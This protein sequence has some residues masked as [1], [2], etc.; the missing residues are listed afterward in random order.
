[1]KHENAKKQRP[2]LSPQHKQFLIEFGKAVR[3]ARDA[4]HWSQEKL[5]FKVGSSR[6]YIS[7]VELGKRPI[8]TT[9]QSLLMQVLGF[10]CTMSVILSDNW[11]DDDSVQ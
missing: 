5:G 1:M 10:T 3:N 4:R 6:Y 2:P 9:K 11:V 7:D 8:C